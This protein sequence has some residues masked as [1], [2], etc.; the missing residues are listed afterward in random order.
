M[1]HFLWCCHFGFG[2]PFAIWAKNCPPLMCTHTH[3]N[4]SE[5]L[6]NELICA[7]TR[8]ES[9]LETWDFANNSGKREF[10][11]LVLWD[12]AEI[13]KNSKTYANN[14]LPTFISSNRNL[15]LKH[16]CQRNPCKCIPIQSGEHFCWLARIK[17][18]RVRNRYEKSASQ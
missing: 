16:Y 11:Q 6:F 9:S 17:L 10:I 12:L 13:N 1:F 4:S 3:I 14:L 7:Y 8:L 5:S 15:V 18:L 2:L